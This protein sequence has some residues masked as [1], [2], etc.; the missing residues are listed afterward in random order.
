MGNA[1]LSQRKSGYKDISD[2]TGFILWADN[3]VYMS[4]YLVTAVGSSNSITKLRQLCIAPDL[5][6][7][8]SWS[9]GSDIVPRHINKVVS[10]KN[11][12][13]WVGNAC[14]SQRK[15]GYKDISDHTGFILWADNFVY[16]SR[17]LVTAVGSSNSITKLRQL[18][19]A[20]DLASS[21]SWSNGSDIVPRHINKVVSS[22]NE[23]YW[24]GNAFVPW[25]PPG[26][27]GVK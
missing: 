6:S 14:L 1:C 15:S 18:C 3:F 20:P 12:A 5:A 10:S 7:S 23:A 27:T 4:R 26:K 24:V 22:K 17:Y 8:P 21:P 13:Y 19:I 16:M 2:H 9:N 11:E 25:F